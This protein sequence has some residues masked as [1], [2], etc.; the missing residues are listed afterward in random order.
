MWGRRASH[1]SHRSYSSHSFHHVHSRGLN[2]RILLLVALTC[3][4][5]FDVLFLGRGF[6]KGDLFPYHFPMKKVVRDLGVADGIPYWNP[7]YHAGQPLAANPAY[8]LFYPPQWL[9]YVGSYPFAFQLHILLHIAIA[10]IGMYLLLRELE[11]RD[12]AALFG[13]AAFAFGAPYLSLLIRLP[14]LFAMTWLPLVI[15]C[16]RRVVLHG[17]PRDVALGAIAFGL[18]ALIGEPTTVLQT[19]ALVAAYIIYKKAWKALPRIALMF[20]GGLAIAAVHL[21]PAVDHARDT[22]RA[23]GFNWQITSN[24][25]TPP[26]RVAELAYPQLWRAMRNPQGE[27]A[28]R[29]MYDYR[30]EPYIS[31]IYVGLLLA[32]LILAGIIRGVRGR[33]FVVV[34]TLLSALFAFGQ[35]GPF[36]K[37]L[38]DWHLLPSIRY[39]EKFLLTGLFV[40]LVWGTIVLDR[41]AEDAKLRKLAIGIVAVWMIVGAFVWISGA[42]VTLPDPQLAEAAAIPWNAYWA[43][44]LA[45]GAAVIALLVFATRM[46]GVTWAAALL[47]FVCLDNAFMHFG[48]A[49]RISRDFYA[50]PKAAAQLPQGR[51][52]YRVFNKAAWDEWEG[53]PLA[54]QHFITAPLTNYAVRDAMFPFAPA[55]HGFRLALEDDLDQTALLTTTEFRRAALDVKQRTGAWHPF[56]LQASGVRYVAQWLPMEQA[57]QRGAPVDFTDLGETPRFRFATRTRAATERAE[58]A[59]QLVAGSA[60]PGDAFIRPPLF[61]PAPAR[62]LRVQERPTHVTLD[63]ESS[64]QALLVASIT[65]HKY[66]QAFIDGNRTENAATN[67]AYQGVVVP[68]G[69]HVV[70]L[71]YRNPLVVPALVVSVVALLGAIAVVFWRR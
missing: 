67:V 35:Y 8:E 14:F 40:L 25:S 33:W 3:V 19:G 49:E 38:H 20:A 18:Q 34:V 47:A 60:L 7:A 1:T 46:R 15:L 16:A 41:V 10:A 44:N 29:T 63:V 55:A 62:I 39:P 71:R 5:F 43:M 36:L 50:E 59:E 17:R 70:E 54:Y 61:T 9:I 2:R 37:L 57:R 24:W 64:G 53:D 13:A 23:E 21:V 28:I 22:V 65:R 66:W 51:E 69:K 6:F 52:S 68:A 11:V 48:Q 42:T 30:I 32:A 58:L 12:A 26:R 4:L 56:L 31:D 45:R 27:Q